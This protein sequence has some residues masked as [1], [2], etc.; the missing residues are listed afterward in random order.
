MNNIED[1][2][3]ISIRFDFESLVFYCFISNLIYRLEIIQFLDL[4]RNYG[5]VCVCWSQAFYE[6]Y[7][8]MNMRVI[9]LHLTPSSIIIISWMSFKLYIVEVQRICIHSTNKMLNILA[10][11]LRNI[12]F[13]ISIHKWIVGFKVEIIQ[14]KF[15]F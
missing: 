11:H 15:S 10:Y 13:V 8:E 9:S 2:L 5:H 14:S 6:Y 7:I 3:S 1:S 12:G 4:F